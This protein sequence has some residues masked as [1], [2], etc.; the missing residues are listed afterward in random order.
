MS[1]EGILADDVYDFWADPAIIKEI[2]KGSGANAE[3]IRVKL[4]GTLSKVKLGR[5][6]SPFVERKIFTDRAKI[7]ISGAESS[8]TTVKKEI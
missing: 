4:G 8:A 5:T 1:K 7:T 6:I 3:T 2:T